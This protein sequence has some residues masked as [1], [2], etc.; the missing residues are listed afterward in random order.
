MR[1][2]RCWVAALVL[3]QSSIFG[4][5]WAQ[6]PLPSW[7]SRAAEADLSNDVLQATYFHRGPSWSVPSALDFGALVSVDRQFIGSSTLLLGTVYTPIPRFTLAFGPKAY[8]GILA[9][10]GKTDVLGIGAG[11]SA[12]WDLIRAIGFGVF[13]NIYYVPNVL[14]FGS[15]HSVTDVSLGGEVNVTP[16]LVAV[17]GYRFL[18]FTLND[19]PD[20]KVLDEVFIG[21]RWQFR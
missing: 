14:V 8:L 16:R 11:A 19:Q 13:G 17:G 6:Q 18:N 20:D 3:L 5:A 1:S 10:R 12:R 9:G 2:I 21:L 15:G 4:T 7:S